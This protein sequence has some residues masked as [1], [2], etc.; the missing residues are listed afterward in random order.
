[1]EQGKV[2]PLDSEPAINAASYGVELQ[3]LLADSMIHATAKKYEARVW[4]GDSDLKGLSGVKF[5]PK[6]KAK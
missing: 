3:L 1:M 2:V 4:T 6:A 5:Y